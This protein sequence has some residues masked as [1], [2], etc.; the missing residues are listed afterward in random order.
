MNTL[1]LNKKELEWILGFAVIGVSPTTISVVFLERYFKLI[2]IYF[3]KIYNN[4]DANYRNYRNYEI[5][6]TTHCH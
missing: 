6:S 5:I 3:L 1:L 4:N 2:I